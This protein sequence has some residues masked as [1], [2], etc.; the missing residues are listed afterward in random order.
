[1]VL[2]SNL[3]PNTS[4]IPIDECQVPSSID[5]VTLSDGTPI[6]LDVDDIASGQSFRI[7]WDCTPKLEAKPGSRFSSDTFEFYYRNTDTGQVFPHF[8]SI[9]GKWGD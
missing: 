5:S 4:N 9:D 3:I 6:R 1:L 7:K 2:G 8:G